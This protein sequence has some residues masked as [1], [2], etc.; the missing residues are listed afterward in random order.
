MALPKPQLA[1][2]AFGECGRQ[3]IAV[4]EI[5]RQRRRSRPPNRRPI[6]CRQPPSL[7]LIA[8]L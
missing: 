3:I 6:L 4:S 8:I 7:V 5:R 1:A 2:V